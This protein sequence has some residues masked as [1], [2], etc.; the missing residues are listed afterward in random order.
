VLLNHGGFSSVVEGL[1]AG[2]RLVLLPMKG[3]QYL[4]AALFARDLRVGVE[5]AR[6][7]E[8]GW[9]GRGDV[10]DAVAAAM[11]DGGDGDLRKWREFLTDDAVQ[12]RFPDEFV[13]QLKELV[14]ET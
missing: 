3:D 14:R 5:V 7:D 4:N 8:D 11:A 9:F 1:V 13:R 10:A 2:C 6:R 12:M